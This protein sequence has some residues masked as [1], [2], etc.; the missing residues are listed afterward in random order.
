MNHQQHPPAVEECK[1]LAIGFSQIDVDASGLGHGGAQFGK[2]Q[3]PGERQH[4]AHDPD[5]EQAADAAYLERDVVRHQED[6]RPD[7]RAHHDGG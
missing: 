2:G 1:K 4:A 6:P 3:S 7:D 5:Q